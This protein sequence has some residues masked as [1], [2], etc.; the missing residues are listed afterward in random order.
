MND[1]KNKIEQ[2]KE[3]TTSGGGGKDAFSD[4]MVEVTVDM[5]S[6]DEICAGKQREGE[7]DFHVLF[8]GALR[9]N[10]SYHPQGLYSLLF[11]AQWTKTCSH[12]QSRTFKSP[13]NDERQSK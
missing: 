6:N 5:F 10:L 7:E 13:I 3:G 2:V 12:M 4:Y 8:G 11:V 9:E 1:C